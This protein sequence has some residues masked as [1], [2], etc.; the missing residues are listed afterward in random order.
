M[1]HPLK[2]FFKPNYIY[3]YIVDL[4]RNSNVKKYY[5]NNYNLLEIK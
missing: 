5:I 2:K 1:H 3:I 4:L